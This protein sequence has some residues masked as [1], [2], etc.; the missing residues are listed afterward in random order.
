MTHRLAIY[1]M[2]RTVTFSGT[3]TGFLIHMARAMAPWRL[4]LLRRA[5]S[6][7]G[8]AALDTLLKVVAY[9]S[10]YECM[11]RRCINQLPR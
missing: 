2:D 9:V 5:V 8:P 11:C 6:L 1:D 7:A 3:Y 10:V 4:A